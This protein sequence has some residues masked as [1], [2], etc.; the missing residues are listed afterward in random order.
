M[1]AV[2]VVLVLVVFAGRPAALAADP[3]LSASAAKKVTADETIEGKTFK[4]DG[5]GLIVRGATVT[6]KNCTIDVAGH[7]LVLDANADVKVVNCTIVGRK[8]ALWIRANGDVYATGTKW[9]GKQIIDANG[10]YHDEK[11]NSWKNK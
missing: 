1:R 3:E 9:N 4:G 10:D 8:S 11:E 7:A 5:D 2:S 6:L